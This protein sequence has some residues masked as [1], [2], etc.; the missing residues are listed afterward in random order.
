MLEKDPKKRITV[1]QIK[2]DPWITQEIDESTFNFATLVPCEHHEI[3][4][5]KYYTGT[6][7]VSNTILSNTSSHDS[8]SLVDDSLSIGVDSCESDMDDFKGKD[9]EKKAKGKASANKGG[10]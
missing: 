8:L 1:K 4:P 5:E 7:Y 3:N 9:K 10:G 6:M 2:E